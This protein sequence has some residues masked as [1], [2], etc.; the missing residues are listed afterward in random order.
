MESTTS[1]NIVYS[2]EMSTSSGFCTT[3]FCTDDFYN[4]VCG[5]REDIHLMPE[6]IEIR[7]YDPDF[8]WKTLDANN[9]PEGL[10]YFPYYAEFDGD[11]CYM[12]PNIDDLVEDLNDFLNLSVT[13][14]NNPEY[15]NLYG[16]A[17]VFKSYNDPVGN[18]CKENL[19]IEKSGVSFYWF[20]CINREFNL[21]PHCE[22]PDDPDPCSA[23]D[24]RPTLTYI[25]PV[26]GCFQS[27]I[28]DD[29]SNEIE[30]DI[31]KN[32][33]EELLDMRMDRMHSSFDCYP[34]I[35]SGEVILDWNSDNVL[36]KK[37]T[38]YDLFGKE[39]KQFNVN[40]NVS[41]IKLDLSNYKAGVYLIKLVDIVSGNYIIK[42]IIKQ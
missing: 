42:K 22:Y 24:A 15:V 3:Y 29:F 26:F 5:D 21:Y 30:H 8:G 2:S 4:G 28:A 20:K 35:T 38:V 23:N 7:Y 6:V 34:T 31:E 40:P 37:I 18:L 39:S 13:N 14:S 12:F 32:M 36:G 1:S 9:N 10:F 16:H 19:G 33:K 27:S 41:N 25:P 17:R 11:A